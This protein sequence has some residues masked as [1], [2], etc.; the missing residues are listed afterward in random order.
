[1]VLWLNIQRTVYC[2]SCADK[3]TLI[4]VQYH[5]S[6]DGKRSSAALFPDFKKIP[7]IPQCIPHKHEWQNTIVCMTI[8]AQP[9]SCGVKP[10]VIVGSVK[11]GID[12]WRV[13]RV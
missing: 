11:Y 13:S 7:S 2:S 8:K 9:Y 6:M 12:H 3:G 1:M 5:P 10:C 4:H